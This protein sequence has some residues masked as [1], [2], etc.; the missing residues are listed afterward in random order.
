MSSDTL[1]RLEGIRDVVD[2]DT[3]A[4]ELLDAWISELED[5]GASTQ[6]LDDTGG[7][8]NEPPPGS[9]GG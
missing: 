3:D 5:G 1:T 9:G 8:G 2:D 7:G 6:G 4:A